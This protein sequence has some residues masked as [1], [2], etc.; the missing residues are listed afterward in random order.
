MSRVF[1]VSVSLGAIAGFV[2]TNGNPVTPIIIGTLIGMSV[3][4]INKYAFK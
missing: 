2:F 4:M 3:Y 1:I